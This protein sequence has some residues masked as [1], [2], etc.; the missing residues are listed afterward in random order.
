MRKCDCCGVNGLSSKDT[1]VVSNGIQ[2]FHVCINCFEN[3]QK[4]R[5]GKVSGE[6]LIA[7]NIDYID[8]GIVRLLQEFQSES[9]GTTQAA[10]NTVISIQSNNDSGESGVGNAIKILSVILIM[11]SVIGS[12]ALF[13]ISLVFGIAG[14]VTSVLV[15]MLCY[16]IGEIC[17]RLASIDAKLKSG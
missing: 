11:G 3:I 1:M 5:S 2:D 13:R 17:C 4:V 8:N 7:K 10:G 16:G 6:N 14:I 9:S 15:G 12:I